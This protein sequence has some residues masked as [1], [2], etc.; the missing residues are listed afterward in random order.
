[1]TKRKKSPEF[2]RTLVYGVIIIALVVVGYYGF[3]SISGSSAAGKIPGGNLSNDI[4]NN[5]TPTK[6]DVTAA[7][8]AS[9]PPEHIVLGGQVAFDEVA[10]YNFTAVGSGFTV[11]KLA[12]IIPNAGWTSVSMLQIE[13]P[14]KTGQTVIKTVSPYAEK[15][16]FSALTLYVPKNGSSV[17]TVKARFKKIGVDGGTFKAHTKFGLASGAIAGD[18]YATPENSSIISADTRVAKQDIYGDTHILYNSKPTVVSA[19][20]SGGG[21][22]VPGS[23]VDLYKFKVTAD[24]SGAIALKNFTIAVSVDDVSIPKTAYLSDFTFMRGS[25]DITTSAQIT[26]VSGSTPLT[27]EDTN[28]VGATEQGIL[29]TPIQIAFGDTP[30]D[31]G[32]QLIPAG[33]SVIYTLRAKCSPE[34]TTGDSI[35]VVLELLNVDSDGY[36]YLADYD[37]DIGGVEQLITLQNA[38]GAAMGDAEAYLNFIWSDMSALSHLPNFDDAGHDVISSPDWATSYLIWD[39]MPPPYELKL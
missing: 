8:D 37:M 12:L 30:A 33:Q 31:G 10:K 35:N 2:N 36:D 7:L 4:G 23:V 24:P 22:I 28:H 18:F 3:K 25:V 1:M 13:Y 26:D 27:L 20:P 34:F 38:Q 6:I 15:T 21:V 14:D 17:M 16:K 5:I 39:V 9:S 32:E 19:N 11:R 29:A